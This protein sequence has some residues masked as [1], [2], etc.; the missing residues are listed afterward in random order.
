MVLPPGPLDKFALPWKKVCGRPWYMVQTRIEIKK[1]WIRLVGFLT[2]VSRRII[3]EVLLK[4][5][6][7]CERLYI[8]NKARKS[9]KSPLSNK[10]KISIFS[11]LPIFQMCCHMLF[12][13]KYCINFFEDVMFLDKLL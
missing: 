7:D 11:S 8:K 9:R 10:Q 4:L 12:F 5:S 6:K 3:L 13:L 2:F 1:V